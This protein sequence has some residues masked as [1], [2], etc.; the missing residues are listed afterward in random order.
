LLAPFSD[1]VPQEVRD[2]VEEANQK[3]ASGEID[4]PAT[5]E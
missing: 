4:P 2:A 3:L 1:A 5:L